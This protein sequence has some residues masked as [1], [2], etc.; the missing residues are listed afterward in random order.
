VTI[1]GEVH[2]YRL[3]L[4]E[5]SVVLALAAD[6]GKE[7]RSIMREATLRADDCRLNGGEGQRDR[8]TA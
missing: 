2:G 3:H 8:P 1:G 7:Q 4:G 5:R 6:A